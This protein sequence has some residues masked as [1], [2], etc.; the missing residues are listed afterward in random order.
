MLVSKIFS[1]SY[2]V[3]YQS[4]KEFLFLSYIYFVVCK[5][6]Q[7]GLVSKFVVSQRFDI[8]SQTRLMKTIGGQGSEN[9]ENTGYCYF[10]LFSQCIGVLHGKE[11]TCLTHNPG[12]MGSS[13][14][15]SGF[16]V[17]V[18]VGKTLQS[19]SLVLVKPG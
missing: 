18:P 19:I 13:P 14:T 10:L 6:F 3:L 16:L 9:K 11:V 5:C 7:V 12:V 8:H 15:G 1:F 2:N 17:G 4:H